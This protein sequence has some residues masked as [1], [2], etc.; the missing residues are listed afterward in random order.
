MNLKRHFR[1]AADTAL[2][3]GKDFAVSL[4]LKGFVT[5][6]T[7]RIAPDGR[8]PL[9]FCPV[10]TGPVFGLSSIACLAADH[11]GCLARGISLQ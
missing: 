11:S 6:L 2:R 1:L 4:P 7:S 3:R 9:P 5:V 8:Y 10:C